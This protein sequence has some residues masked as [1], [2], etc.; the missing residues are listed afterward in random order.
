M[1]LNG[2]ARLSVWA[3]LFRARGKKFD[4]NMKGEGRILGGLFVVGPGDQGVVFE[5]RES[6]FGDHAS[7]DDIMAA[8][9][10]IRAHQ[11]KL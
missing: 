2:F 7:L 9:E 10:Q 8:V 6:E 5:Y 11:A 4:G 1:G 3:S